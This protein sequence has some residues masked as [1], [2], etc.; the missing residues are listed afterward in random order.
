MAAVALGAH[1]KPRGPAPVDF[2]CWDSLRGVWTSEMGDERPRQT[3]QLKNE[4]RSERR[5]RKRLAQREAAGEP[6][7]RKRGRPADPVGKQQRQ[8][9]RERLLLAW[10]ERHPWARREWRREERRLR[11]EEQR[12][13]CPPSLPPPPPQ[14]RPAPQP[15]KPRRIVRSTRVWST[16]GQCEGITRSGERCRVHTSSKYAVAQLLRH[17]ERFCGHHHASK[18]TGVR[19]AGIKKHG[20]GQCRVWSGSV[21]SDAMPLRRGSPFCHHHRVRCEGQTCAGVRCA[22]TSSSEHTH[23]EP[24]RQG[25]RYCMHHKEQDEGFV[26]YECEACDGLSALRVGVACTHICP[27]SDSSYPRWRANLEAELPM[28]MCV[29]CDADG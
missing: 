9:E 19:C 10:R 26:L 24:L 7:E 14:S 28:S 16:K 8:D 4:Q 20:K 25:K 1:P 12:L 21:Y 13:R 6:L 5:R 27:A 17:G 11:Q 29:E 18:Y 3:L 15:P 23:A 22:V 2:P